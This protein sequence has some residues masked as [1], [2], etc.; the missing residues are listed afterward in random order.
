MFFELIATIVAGVAAAGVALLLVRVSRGRLP[1]WLVPLVAGAAMIAFTINSEYSWFG[2]TSAGL[3]ENMVVVRQVA[4]RAVY[5]PWTYLVPY[6]DRFVALDRGSIRR[7][8]AAPD[9]RLADLFVFGRWAPIRQIPV[10]VDCAGKR[11][12][13][14]V[15]DVRFADDGTIPEA[16]WRD[17][18][19]GDPLIGA[20]CAEV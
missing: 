10:L 12:A 20:A 9:Q 19:P 14:L 13:D 15:D 18:D 4:G 5:R 2:R 11:R 16:A 3:P 1:R 6:T 17:L 7:N 8:E